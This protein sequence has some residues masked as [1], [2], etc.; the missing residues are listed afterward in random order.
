M[1]ENRNRRPLTF[2]NESERGERTGNPPQ[3]HAGKGV[4]G[5]M[6]RATFIREQ[7][8]LAHLVS[9]GIIGDFT[10]ITM[11]TRDR[12]YQPGDPQLIICSKNESSGNPSVPVPGC[13]RCS[14]PI[15][16]RGNRLHRSWPPPPGWRGA[17]MHRQV[18]PMKLRKYQIKFLM[19]PKCQY[20][21]AEA[22]E[23]ND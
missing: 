22:L 20:E 17:T 1:R 18:T 3:V 13:C 11:D 4:A 12:L 8:W 6:G 14:E 19:C 21:L 5:F 16:M 2:P 23:E 10:F 9:V 7:R 15:P